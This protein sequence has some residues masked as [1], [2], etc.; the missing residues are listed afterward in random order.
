MLFRSD[1]FTQRIYAG[2]ASKPLISMNRG[3]LKR[4]AG[5]RPNA[6]RKLK[7]SSELS[8]LTLYSLTVIHGFVNM[9]GLMIFFHKQV[10][11]KSLYR[12]PKKTW[13]HT[14]THTHTEQQ[15][16]THNHRHTHTNIEPSC[17]SQREKS[18]LSSSEIRVSPFLTAR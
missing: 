12:P 9:L 6:N 4:N 15:T 18:N 10:H 17:L 8:L 13:K 16:H 14:H 2:C 3:T 1:G 11:R 7:G 5:H